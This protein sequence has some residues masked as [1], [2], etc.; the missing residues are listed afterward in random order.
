MDFSSWKP[1]IINYNI[2]NNET[3]MDFGLVPCGTSKFINDLF[4]VRKWHTPKLLN[5]LKWESKVKTI[6]EQGVGARS[7]ARSTL[8]VEG[9]AR[10]SGWD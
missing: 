5:R 10:A 9:H 2:H 6:E 8:G 1:R 4:S 7:W 3:W